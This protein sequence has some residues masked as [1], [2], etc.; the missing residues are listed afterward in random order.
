MILGPDWGLSAACRMILS[1]STRTLNGVVSQGNPSYQDVKSPQFLPKLR[2]PF[3]YELNCQYR[4]AHALVQTCHD[5]LQTSASPSFSRFAPSV[6]AEVA[7][8][9][10]KSPCE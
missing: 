3:N 4:C 10:Y 6:V 5:T 7:K 8:F 1:N 2:A 9:L